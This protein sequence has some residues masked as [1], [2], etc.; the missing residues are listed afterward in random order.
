MK[1]IINIEEKKIGVNKKAN[2]KANMG[3]TP[4]Q[5]LV[6]GFL[7]LIL[8]GALLLTLPQATVDGNGLNFLDAFFTATSA[9]C[10]TGLVVVDTG[11]TFTIF[12]QLVIMFLIQVGGIGFMTFATLFA[13]ILGRKITLKERLL[14]QEAL[15]QMSIEGIVRLAKYIIKVSLFIELVGAV[16]FTFTWYTDL[17]WGKALYYGIFHAISGFNNAGFDLFGNYSSLTTYAGSFVTN[18]TMMF[19]IITGGFGF[20]VLSDLYTYKGRKLTLHS[21]VV[22]RMS[23]FLIIVGAILILLLEYTNASSLA[24]LNPLDKVIAAVFQSVTTRTAGFNT[25]DISSLKASTHIIIVL[26]MFIGAS[27]GSTGGGIKTTTFT[28]IV[29]S[30]VSTLRG[31]CNSSFKERTIPKEIIQKAV[32]ITFMAMTLVFVIAFFLS[33]T[34]DADFMTLL[35]ETVSAFGT[36]GLSMGI[37]PNLTIL[38]KAA[39]IFTMFCGRIGPLT[40]VFALGRKKNKI[41]GLDHI[42]YPEEKFLIG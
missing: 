1:E 41:N 21:K 12:G 16:I 7:S 32:A 2:K 29:L 11:T 35:F 19:L 8:C 17:G 26:L 23:S 14:L 39:I 36:V 20:A 27:P 34:E 6:V 31:S 38:G 9:I 10:V 30:V 3:N 25:I 4:A 33:I 13:I 42:K 18:I 24:G 37:T 40:L 28:A 22:I 5:I 15:N